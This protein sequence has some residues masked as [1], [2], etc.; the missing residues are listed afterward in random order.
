MSLKLNAIKFLFISVIC[1]CLSNITSNTR[2]LL[3]DKNYLFLEYLFF[4]ITRCHDFFTSLLY[5]LLFISKMT[6]AAI[7]M[8]TSSPI[9]KYSCLICTKIS[10]EI[11]A[12]CFDIH[13]LF[14]ELHSFAFNAFNQ[15]HFYSFI[16]CKY[17]SRI[18]QYCY[19]L[20]KLPVIFFHDLRHY[21]RLVKIKKNFFLNSKYFKVHRN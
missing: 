15:E 20:E 21:T 4:Y 8:R 13:F 3:D 14:T 12:F 19:S 11:Y 6:L 1:S 5:F 9:F 7:Y 10:R 17:S 16:M 18:R 2:I